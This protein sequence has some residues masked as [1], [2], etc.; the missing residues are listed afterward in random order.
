MIK[1]IKEPKP[2]KTP[3][4]KTSTNDLTKATI[5]MLLLIGFNV[6]RNNNGAVYD[7]TRRAFRSNSSTPGI[8]D[9]IG[10]RRNSGQFI[11]VEIK[12]GK[13]VM[14]D[15]Q[16][17]FLNALN[18]NGGIGLVVRNIDDVENLKQLKE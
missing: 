1:K 4:P 8:S 15:A 18:N 13:D 11:A 16:T 17:L 12:N 5:K 10:Y 6:W 2:K 3:I 9:I 7:P 14:S